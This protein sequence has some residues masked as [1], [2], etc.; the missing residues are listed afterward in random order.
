MEEDRVKHG[1]TDIEF[2]QD[3]SVPEFYQVHCGSVAAFDRYTQHRGL[4]NLS[5]G[6]GFSFGP[7][8]FEA[9]QELVRRVH[10]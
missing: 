6:T 1:F 2:R 3:P 8:A 9:A 4:T 7:G 5:K 10:G